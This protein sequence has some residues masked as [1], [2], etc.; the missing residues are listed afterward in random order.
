MSTVPATSDETDCLLSSQPIPHIMGYHLFAGPLAM[1]Y[2][3]ER[4]NAPEQPP[5]DRQ[6][7]L[8]AVNLW[9]TNV[10]SQIPGKI[11][12]QE[13][14]G[15]PSLFAEVGM[16]SFGAL[17]LKLSCFVTG[18]GMPSKVPCGWRFYEN[19]VI[20]RAMS[21]QGAM[22]SFLITDMFIPSPEVG[23]TRCVGPAGADIT[24]STTG[25]LRHDLVAI[26]SAIWKASDEEIA[27]WSENPPAS[28]GDV[29]TE[30]AA[31]YAF[32][33]FCRILFAAENG[34]IPIT[35]GH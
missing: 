33:L 34:V 35:V 1:Y 27:S 9:Q 13:G 16:D 20:D 6:Q 7:L 26:N 32:A 3:G 22:P 29:D 25:T 17:M 24:L 30:Q 28:D 21:M 8:D 2:A 11:D 10:A 19:A 4:P 31:R 18:E 12:W 23:A 5:F 15:L 14:Y